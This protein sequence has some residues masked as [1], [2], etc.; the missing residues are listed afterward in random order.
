MGRR[1]K[2]FIAVSRAFNP[3]SNE[4]KSQKNHKSKRKW[5]LRRPKHYH[6][7]P[8]EVAEK[9]ITDATKPPDCHLSRGIKLVKVEA[10]HSKN[11]YSVALSSAAAAETADVAAQAAAAVVGLTITRPMGKSREEAAAIKIQT[12]F[13]RYLARIALQ[14]LR[15][16]VRLK[17]LVDGNAAKHQTSNTLHCMQTLARVRSQIH[18]RRIRMR[19]E[20]QALQRQL[21]LK[22]EMELQKRKVGEEWD[23][24]LR[25]KEQIEANLVNKQEAA[26]RRE[27]ALAYAFSHQWKNSS[28]EVTPT[29]TNPNNPQWGWSW[30]ERWMASRPWENDNAI[31]KDVNDHAKKASPGVG[32]QIIKLYVHQDTN[33]QR[34][35]V[36]HQKSSHP[37]SHH[38]HLTPPS[39]HSS[40][41]KEKSVSSRGATDDS[42]SMVSLQSE[43]RRRQSIGGS[44]FG[45]DASLAISPTIPSYMALTES[46]RAKSRF[47]SPPNNNA[48]TPER[49]SVSAVKKRLSYPVADKCSILSPARIRRN[50]GPPKLD[51]ASLKDVAT[52][53]EQTRNGG[54]R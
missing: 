39:K 5:K 42:R 28:R 2:W 19:E 21:Q 37:S 22:H 38:S 43:R 14:G 31:N 27:R 29:F 34:T 1:G 10:E 53:V 24:S 12:A 13:R 48:E 46:A 15:R 47:Q 41:G 7:V 49:G 35:P 9:S 40:A 52:C 33:L 25:S 50:S 11:A 45:D 6:P 51:V 17:T 26:I 18:S 36:D 54:S 4:K 16:L 8:S 23:D 44:S 32:E 20:N 3:G 30:L